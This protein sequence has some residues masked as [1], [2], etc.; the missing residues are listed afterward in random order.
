MKDYPSIQGSSQAPRKPCIA[1]HKYD[2]SNLRFE[3]SKKR[4]W[5]KFG[6]RKRLF[7]ETD[8]I[9]GPAIPL[10]MN[11]LGDGIIDVIKSNKH[12]RNN[13]RVTVFAEYVGPNSFAGLHDL[14]P[15]NPMELVLFDV[16]LFKYGLIGPREFSREFS[17]LRIPEIVY[18]GNLNEELIAGVRRGDYNLGDG[19]EEGVVCKGGSG[20][21]RDLWMAKIKTQA[22]LD[23]LKAVFGTGWDQYAE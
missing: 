11:T 18:E 3:W 1:F 17:D 21:H 19:I 4:G 10:F 8:D 6:T 23:K 12:W 7:D 22:Y 2:G 16:W 5:H 14:Y 13:E 9:F 15:E 20:G